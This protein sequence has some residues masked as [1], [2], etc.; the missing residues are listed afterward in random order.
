MFVPVK[1]VLRGYG[2][3]SIIIY[4]KYFPV[5]DWLQPHA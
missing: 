3:M 1:Y 2:L 4:S 5:S